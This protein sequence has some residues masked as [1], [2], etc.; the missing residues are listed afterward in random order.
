MKWQFKE[1]TQ[2][3]GLLF[4]HTTEHKAM[5]VYQYKIKLFVGSHIPLYCHTKTERI[6][7][8][9]NLYYKLHESKYL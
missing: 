7:S 9:S 5:I 8:T 6:S 4:V 3:H 2:A 1:K